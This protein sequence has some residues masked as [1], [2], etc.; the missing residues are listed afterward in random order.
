MKHLVSAFGL[1][2]LSATLSAH[3][4][5]DLTEKPYAG[6]IKLTPQIP[7]S[8]GTRVQTEIGVQVTPASNAP[9]PVAAP[10]GAGPVPGVTLPRIPAAGDS[11]PAP[12]AA[13]AAEPAAAEPTP[14]DEPLTKNFVPGQ[15]VPTYATLQQA[16]EA[17]VD[18]LPSMSLENAEP[19]EAPAPQRS[20]DWTDPHAYLAWF[21]SNTNDALLYGGGGFFILLAL[22]W[23][24]LRRS[25]RND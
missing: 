23:L 11:T 18:P 22:G 13:Q 14:A 4:Q 12:P 2:A 16:A 10:A 17:G 25:A 8:V 9:V 19:V 24:A 15:P 6:E 20:F 1:L 21:Q 5:Q 3:A 7:G